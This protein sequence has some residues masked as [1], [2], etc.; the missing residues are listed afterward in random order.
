MNKNHIF[1]TIATLLLIVN[2]IGNFGLS[3]IAMW[4]ENYSE[5]TFYLFVAYL[6][7]KLVKAVWGW[8]LEEK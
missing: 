4:K 7:G 1:K 3:M 6:F 8:M 5:A 2:V